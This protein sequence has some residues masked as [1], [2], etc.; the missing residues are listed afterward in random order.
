MF[1]NSAPSNIRYTKLRKKITADMSNV[2]LWYI[3]QTYSVTFLLNSF[4][5]EQLDIFSFIVVNIKKAE[6]DRAF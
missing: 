6:H 1:I 3:H 2:K 5:N 4:L